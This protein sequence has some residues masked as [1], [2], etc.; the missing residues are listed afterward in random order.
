[1]RTAV[2][3][4]ADNVVTIRPNPSKRSKRS[5]GT[6]TR[7]ATDM[8][9]TPRATLKALRKRAGVSAA[10][11]A[12]SMGYAGPTSYLRYEND[13]MYDERPIPFSVVQGISKLFVGKGV[14]PVRF[15]ELLEISEAKT[16]KSIMPP[17]DVQGRASDGPRDSRNFVASEPPVGAPAVIPHVMIRYRAER[18]VFL[19]ED[20]IADRVYGVAPVLP[21][22]SFPLASQFGV[23]VGDS[24][25]VNDG[26]PPGTV[27]QCVSRE[28]APAGTIRPG[29][30]A[31]IATRNNG[32]VE[33]TVGRVTD[34]NRDGVLGL[35][36]YKYEAV[37]NLE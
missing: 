22:K 31:I 33:I 3:Q 36:L 32:L 20:G 4:K 18:G 25:A 15:E 1:M 11:C 24:H 5:N 29:K 35:V 16:M 19:V 17:P 8:A 30:L 14:P 2:D 28:G 10:S 9:L 12:E 37:Q 13:K 6:G 7:G 27:L 21:F 34:N 23:M 26:I